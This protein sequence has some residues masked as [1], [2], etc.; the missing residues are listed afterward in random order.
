MAQLKRGRKAIAEINV[1]PYIDVMLVLLV[2][3]MVTAPLLTQGIKVELP[4][5]AAE[6]I[7][8]RDLKDQQPLVLSIDREG[9]LYLNQGGRPQS[10]L[11]R[12]TAQARVTAVLRRSPQVPV[13]V[14]GDREVPYGKVVEAMVMLQ[15]AGAAKLGFVTDPLPA[16][17]RKR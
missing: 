2:I 3:F 1:V 11:D 7:D 4:K 17:P 13:L 8:L 12:P 14:K 15:D 5:A 10:P 6:P 9:R 16:D